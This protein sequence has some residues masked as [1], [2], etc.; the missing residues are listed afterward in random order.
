MHSGRVAIVVMLLDHGLELFDLL[1]SHMMQDF[2]TEAT[3]AAANKQ[4]PNLT[5]GT[6][7]CSQRK[8]STKRRN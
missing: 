8:A 2:S 7:M 1:N 3:Q 5:C 4:Q 6:I